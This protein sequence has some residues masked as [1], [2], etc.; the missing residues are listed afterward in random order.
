M[1]VNS[2]VCVPDAFIAKERNFIKFRMKHW[3][4]NHVN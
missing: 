3:K 4:W 2:S 1:R